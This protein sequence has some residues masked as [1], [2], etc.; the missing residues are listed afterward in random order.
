MCT[1]FAPRENVSPDPT[2]TS[3]WTANTAQRLT[4]FFSISSTHS[5]AFSG[6][7][8]PPN[9]F[10]FCRLRTSR[11]DCRG[12]GVSRFDVAKHT[13]LNRAHFRKMALSKPCIFNQLQKSAQLI[14]NTHFQVPLFSHSCALFSCKS[15]ICITYANQWG[16]CTP[17]CSALDLRC[18]LNCPNQAT[19][20]QRFTRAKETANELIGRPRPSRL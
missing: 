5:C 4:P 2:A 20:Y 19:S 11:V 18:C 1:E 6:L 9:H 13:S 7:T 17:A 16:G 3:A 12:W 8:L 10:I 14:E 15:F